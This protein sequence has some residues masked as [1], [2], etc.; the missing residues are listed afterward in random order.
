MAAVEWEVGPT[1]DVIQALIQTLVDPTL[2]LMAS[3][4][5]PPSM[6]AH[7]SVARQMHAV[8]LLYNYYHRKQKPELEFLDHVAFCKLAV[9]LCPS[10]AAFMNLTSRSESGPLNVEAENELSLTE[11]SVKDACNISLSLDASRDVPLVE[12]WPIT[13]V[14]VLLIDPNK[15]NCLLWFGSVTEGVWSLVEKEINEL[16]QGVPADEKVGTKRK[17]VSRK[18]NFQQ[19]AF[20]AVK[21]KSEI[22]RADLVLLETHV[23]YSLSGEKSATQ[24]Y[25]MQ[26]KKPFS[27]NQTVPLKF[28]V[29]SLRGP[30]AKKYGHCWESTAFVEYY[31]MVPYVE[32]IASWLSRKDLCLPSLNGYSAPSTTKTGE[33]ESTSSTKKVALPHFEDDKTLTTK[34]NS[35]K[36]LAL[37]KFPKKS[38]E[39][40]M[41]AEK[42]IYPDFFSEDD[43]EYLKGSLSGTSK[44]TLTMSE[45]TKTCPKSDNSS[46][47]LNSKTIVYNRSR[48]NTPS[49]QNVAHS[50]EATNFKV[51]IQKALKPN[52]TL[53]RD[54][55]KTAEKGAMIVNN[56]SSQNGLVGVTENPIVQ[57]EEPYY[58]EMKNEKDSLD[59]LNALAL[60]A[61][62][63]QALW[64]Q[65][66][67]LEDEFALHEDCMER[68]R[69]VGDSDLA[70]QC[71]N[72]I[73]SH[74][75]TLLPKNEIQILDKGHR[76]VDSQCNMFHPGVSSCDYLEYLCDKNNWRLPRYF[77]KPSD[78][79]F[80]SKVVVT[81]KNFELSVEGIR[82]PIIFYSKLTMSPSPS[83]RSANRDRC[84]PG[85]ATRHCHE[86][87]APDPAIRDAR[88]GSPATPCR[89]AHVMSL[90]GH[91]LGCVRI[92]LWAKVTRLC[93]GRV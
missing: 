39:V 74:N 67:T 88:S 2:P 68:I 79:K 28:L 13:K 90:V 36:T 93:I 64:S 24:F 58:I 22:D 20:D 50:P 91:C 43:Y 11:K 38:N 17:F 80:M 87:H 5:D 48:E 7:T 12:K 78:G 61:R 14:G 16:S 46:R 35:P 54:D 23:T 85:L 31:H 51:A 25:M 59:R 30:L 29:E 83:P 82:E 73:L 76:P 65:I 42:V 37:E 53:C 6:D 55:K 89:V 9:S 41:K 21:E 49:V 56:S 34:E 15:E 72:S 52:D 40:S 32:F 63:R 27:T 26:H 92:E 3:A 84:T 45:S 57:L 66:C 47:K 69:D 1:K 81:G 10:L 18:A 33:K 75:N 70:R 4:D 62:K 86:S 77:V 60:L 19:I 8:V 44:G 71:I